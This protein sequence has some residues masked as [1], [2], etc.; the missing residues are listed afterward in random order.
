[1]KPT[2]L[3]MLAYNILIIIILMGLILLPRPAAGYLDVNKARH[4]D[5]AGDHAIAASAYALA[6][7]RLPWQPALWDKA[8]TAAQLSGNPADAI[9]FL[10]RAAIRNAISQSGWVSLGLA[11]QNIGNIS[12]A[13]KAWEHALPS[14][15][16]YR[17]LARDQRKLGDFPAATADWRAIILQEPGDASA[18]YQLGLLMMTNDPKDAL[19][20]LME[21]AQLNPSLD[22]SVQSLRSS[23]NTA[24][25]SDDRAYQFMMSGRALGALG[26]WN[27]AAEAFHHAIAVRADYGEAWAWLSEAKQQE[28]QDGSIEMEKALALNPNSAMFQG[29]YG[30]YLQ[31]QKQLKQALA[32]FQ[33]AADMEPKDPGWQMALGGTYE[34]NGDLVA[35]LEHYQSA[36]ELSPND[37]VTWRALAEFSLRNGVDLSGTGLP[38]VRRLVELANNDWQADDIAGQILMDTGDLVGAEGLLKKAIELNPTQAAPSLHLGL[39]YLQTGNRAG[40]YSYLNLAKTFD[41]DGP[42]GWQASRLL[43]QYF[44]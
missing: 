42:Y 26:D 39:L 22:A 30:L 13:I 32:A 25:L 36:T 34:Q 10:N 14:A 1:M 37:A 15:K 17:Y 20:V 27:L 16:A 35:A 4:F 28:G 38:A 44:P 7:E 12:L 41:P 8:G 9:L 18:H 23:L 43:E 5:A 31:R 40:A 24:F 29:L 3:Q 21:A 33:K 11:Y 19:P 2:R 6:A